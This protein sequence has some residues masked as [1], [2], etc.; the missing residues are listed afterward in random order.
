MKRVSLRKD[1]SSNL[2]LDTSG[3]NQ[4]TIDEY[5]GCCDVK[6]LSPSEKSEAG[7]ER[8]RARRNRTS[9]QSN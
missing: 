3:P 6:N 7:I 4:D 1:G 9:A 2:T 8:N 5:L